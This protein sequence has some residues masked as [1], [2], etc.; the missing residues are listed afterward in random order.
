MCVFVCVCVLCVLGRRTVVRAVRPWRE[1]GSGAGCC[2]SAAAAHGLIS[3][4]LFFCRLWWSEGLIGMFM[5]VPGAFVPKR[6]L[7]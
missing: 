4:S 6:N 2:F 1:P 3:S 5:S 7:I